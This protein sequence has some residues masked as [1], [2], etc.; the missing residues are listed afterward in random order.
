MFGYLRRAMDG[1]LRRADADGDGAAA[2]AADV[3]PERGR[4]GAG[5][6]LPNAGG[7]ALRRWEAAKWNFPAFRP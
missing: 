6:R 5:R 1:C 4:A 3:Q 2:A 7:R